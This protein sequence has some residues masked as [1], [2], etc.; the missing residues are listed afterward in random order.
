MRH[1]RLPSI[2]ALAKL[3]WSCWSQ[4]NR[5]I[6]K[7]VSRACCTLW[8][9]LRGY[10]SLLS[11]GDLHGVNCV[12][13]RSQDLNTNSEPSHLNCLIASGSSPVVELSKSRCPHTALV[14]AGSVA[15]TCQRHLQFVACTVE[16]RCRAYKC[17]I[18]L[19]P[20]ACAR[21]QSL[22]IQLR[23]GMFQSKHKH[24]LHRAGALPATSRG[25]V[26]N[27]AIVGLPLRS[28]NRRDRR[29]S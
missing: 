28:T 23:P 17:H 1:S 12:G 27:P 19:K 21:S 4:A 14:A 2:Q 6:C 13:G 11:Q 24:D 9:V 20:N 16:L 22:N 15:S 25:G 8:V 26:G 10:Q 29:T 3:T 5:S 7:R 18:I